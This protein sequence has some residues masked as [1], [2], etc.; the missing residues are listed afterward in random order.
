VVTGPR[1]D[2]AAVPVAPGLE[3]Y[4]WVPDL[5][6]HLVACDLTITHGG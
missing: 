1:I 2:P 5:Y 3:V 4:G 6:R